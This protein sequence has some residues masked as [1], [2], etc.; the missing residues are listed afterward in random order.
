[1]RIKLLSIFLAL[2]LVFGCFGLVASAE[3]SVTSYSGFFTD[4]FSYDYRYTFWDNG[5]VYSLKGGYLLISN[6]TNFGFYNSVGYPAPGRFLYMRFYAQGKDKNN[7]WFTNPFFVLQPGQKVTIRYKFAI[8]GSPMSTLNT[9]NG[10]TVYFRIYFN[11]V[12]TDASSASNYTNLSYD[13]ASY[14]SDLISFTYTNNTPSTVDITAIQFGCGNSDIFSGSFSI[15]DLEYHIWTDGELA[16]FANEEA[17]KNQT[18][19]IKA[20]Q[21]KNTDTITNGWDGS[22][23]PPAGSDDVNG[24]L[25]LEDQLMN[26][27]QESIDNFTGGM[28]SLLTQLDTFYTSFLA[29]GLFFNHLLSIPWLSVAVLFSM[30]IGVLALLLNLA[31]LG[32][33]SYERFGRSSKKDKGG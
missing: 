6:S 2:V 23:T 33:S 26:S 9:L 31:S 3:S 4:G 14:I 7:A 19:E 16:I 17:I 15:R 12:I 20:N 27:Q 10:R 28:S 11:D 25:E 30:T 29:I 1:M 8:S 13:S 32:R 24:Y 5:N 18:E 21:D 22:G